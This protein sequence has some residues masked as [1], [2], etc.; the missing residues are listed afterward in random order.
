VQGIASSHPSVSSHPVLSLIPRQWRI[1]PLLE[2]DE[3]F[4]DILDA[5]QY[6]NSI[7]NAMVFE[8]NQIGQLALAISPTPSPTY[9]ASTKSMNSR[10]LRCT[11]CRSQASG[12]A[13][14]L[15]WPRCWV[16]SICHILLILLP[17]ILSSSI[18]TSIPLGIALVHMLENRRALQVVQF[19]RICPR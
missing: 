17:V 12:A 4:P 9:W 19:R 8:I 1:Q 6:L 5:T 2:A 3:H 15:P 14:V 11:C 10:C 7:L 16:N 13:P 18:H